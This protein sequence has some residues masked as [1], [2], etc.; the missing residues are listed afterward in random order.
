MSTLSDYTGVYAGNWGAARWGRS[1]VRAD[2]L[3]VQAEGIL[4]SLQVFEI[5]FEGADRQPVV[6]VLA[7][8][9]E[10]TTGKDYR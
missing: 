3:T 2:H 8:C 7:A 6:D 10:K 5:S 1:F 4:G 9:N